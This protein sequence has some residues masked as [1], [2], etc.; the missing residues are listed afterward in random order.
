MNLE[1]SRK[2][3]N[4]ARSER[5]QRAIKRSGPW[6]ANDWS[7]WIQL[8]CNI[9]PFYRRSLLT[10]SRPTR[11]PVYFTS[12]VNS[13]LAMVGNG[14]FRPGEIREARVKNSR[15]GGGRDGE[16]KELLWF[17][18]GNCELRP[19]PREKVAE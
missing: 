10:A 6:K 9:E 2:S 1:I 13:S 16:A 14:P 4:S 17:E 7:R 19:G 3:T 8:R 12:V 5:L 11:L 15:A 18:T